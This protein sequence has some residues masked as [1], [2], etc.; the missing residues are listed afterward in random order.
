[1][2]RA[3]PDHEGAAEP[4]VGPHQPV[5]QAEPPAERER[6]RLFRQER[7][8]A[9]FHEKAVAALGRDGAA[10]TVPRLEQREVER[11]PP[12]AG[13]L[14]RPMRGREAGD[15]AAHHDELHDV[16]RPPALC[17]TRSTSIAMKAG[18]SLAA[19]AR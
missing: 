18:W 16:G 19:A 11:E 10:Q 7:V 9:A 13:Q 2:E 12:L 1:M 17:L 5:F 6:P 8:G 15:P 3:A 14:H 4:I